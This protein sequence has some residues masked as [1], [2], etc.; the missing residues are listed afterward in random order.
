MTVTLTYQGNVDL[1]VGIARSSSPSG[2]CTGYGCGI[3]VV[4]NSCSPCEEPGSDCNYVFKDGDLLNVWVNDEDHDSWDEVN[5]YS[6]TFTYDQ[7][8]PSVCS[9]YVCSQ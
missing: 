5:A 7:G 4:G 3:S 1:R 8:C 6:F 9:Q 2:W